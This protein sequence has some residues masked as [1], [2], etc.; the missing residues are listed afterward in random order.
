MAGEFYIC[1]S[2]NLYIPMKKKYLLAVCSL[3]LFCNL[4][5]AQPDEKTGAWYMYFWNAS[6]NESSWG[7]QGDV[8]LRH[9]ELTNDL[10]QLFLRAG[11]SYS[12]LPNL[13]LTTGY[14]NITIGTYGESKDISHENRLYQQASIPHKIGKRI[15]LAHR[16]RYEQRWIDQQD[17]RTRYR[18]NFYLNIPLNKTNF[19]K[20]SLYLSFFSEIFLNGQ[21]EIAPQRSVE[22]FDR[23]RFYS[24][25]GYSFSDKLRVQL[26]YLRQVTNALTTGQIQVGLHHALIF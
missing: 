26:G 25:L 9:Y 19:L 7:L 21:K 8:Q 10:S 15:H 6:F 18:Y 17:F 23:H 14:A 4:I 1:H 11:V 13:E 16:F 3:L 20:N 24:A 5:Q 22:I 12:P 2:E